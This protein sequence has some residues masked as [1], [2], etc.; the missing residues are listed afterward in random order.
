MSWADDN[1]SQ[2]YDDWGDNNVYIDCY[3]SVKY[4]DKSHQVYFID[5]DGDIYYV[6][7]ASRLIENDKVPEFITNNKKYYVH[8]K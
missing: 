5:N 3:Y 8:I 1:L 6:F 7:C 2:G 4:N